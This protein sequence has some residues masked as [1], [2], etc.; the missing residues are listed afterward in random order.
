MTKP[1]RKLTD[2]RVRFCETC[3]PGFKCKLCDKTFGKTLRN[4]STAFHQFKTDVTNYLVNN[5]SEMIADI[6]CPR[7]V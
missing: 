6:G 5:S 3:D 2:N 7:S 1:A 4:Q